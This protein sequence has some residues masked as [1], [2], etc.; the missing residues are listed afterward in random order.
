M[1]TRAARR[2][3]ERRPSAFFEDDSSLASGGYAGD[4]TELEE[5]DECEVVDDLASV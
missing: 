3:A 1:G 2:I 4:E 5:R